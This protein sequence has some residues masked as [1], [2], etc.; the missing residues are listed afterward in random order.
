[1][2]DVIIGGEQLPAPADVV[3]YPPGTVWMNVVRRAADATGK[4]VG[5]NLYSTNMATYVGYNLAGPG[6]DIPAGGPFIAIVNPTAW[7][8]AP[9]AGQPGQVTIADFVIAKAG[10]YHFEAQCAGVRRHVDVQVGAPGIDQLG[11]VWDARAVQENTVAG[12]RAR[13][14]EQMADVWRPSPVVGRPSGGRVKM[15]RRVP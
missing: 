6:Y 13:D 14:R 15:P 1:M 2:P 8:T 7:T 10:F 12:R 11:P 5:V 3:K 4:T 9:T